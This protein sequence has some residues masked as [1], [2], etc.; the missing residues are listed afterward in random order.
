MSRS[1]RRPTFRNA[2]NY[3]VNINDMIEY[4]VLYSLLWF[5]LSIF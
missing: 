4:V 1:V 3:R 2:L 5:Y